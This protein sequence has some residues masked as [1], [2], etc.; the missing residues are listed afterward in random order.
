MKINYYRVIVI[1]AEGTIHENKSMEMRQES[2]Q[3]QGWPAK[4]V[5]I[6]AQ[7]CEAYAP[8]L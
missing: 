8:A 7:Q 2:Q 1:N 4:C 5:E 6:G 3:G